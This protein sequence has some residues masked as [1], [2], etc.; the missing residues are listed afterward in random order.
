MSVRSSKESDASSAP[1]PFFIRPTPEWTLLPALLRWRTL[2]VNRHHPVFRPWLLTAPGDPKL[3]AFGLA[4]ALLH[5]EDIEPEG[6]FDLLIEG[7]QLES[8]S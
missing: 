7:F 5:E 8:A 6:T 4:Q 2:L 3:A 1:K